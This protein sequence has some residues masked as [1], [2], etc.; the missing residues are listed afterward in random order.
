[1]PTWIMEKPADALDAWL[2]PLADDPA[3][4]V[5]F[6][7]EVTDRVAHRGGG[8]VLV[9]GGGPVADALAGEGYEVHLEPGPRFDAGYLGADVLSRLPDQRDQLR[10][11]GR[12]SRLLRPGG[13]LVVQGRHPDPTCWAADRRVQSVDCVRQIVQLTDASLPL[14]YVWPAELDL[15]AE[16][17]GLALEHRWGG[18]YGEPVSCGGSVVS[19]YRS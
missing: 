10:A 3:G 8:R 15:M 7:S 9:P 17:A 4:A 11:I 13:A 19:V 5:A 14:R 18:W 12:Y 2:A 1:M 16:L 6:L